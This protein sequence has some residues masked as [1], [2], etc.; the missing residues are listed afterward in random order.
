M[1]FKK[2]KFWDKNNQ[3]IFSLIFFPFFKRFNFATKY[4]IILKGNK[5]S[6]NIVCLFLSQNLGFLNCIKYILILHYNCP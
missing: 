6:E 3:T 5:I 1:Q 4:T 2:P